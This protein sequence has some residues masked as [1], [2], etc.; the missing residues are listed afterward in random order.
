MRAPMP[1]APR[2]VTMLQDVDP[3]SI[4]DEEVRRIVVALLNLVEQLQADNR[5]LAEENRRLRNE[6]NRLKGEQGKPEFKPKPAPSSSDHSSEKERKRPRTWAKSSKLPLIRIDRTEPLYVDRSTLP[7]DAQHKGYE[8]VVVQDIIFRS[9]NICFRRE[10]FYSPATRR[11]YLAP[12]PEGYEG[13]FGPALKALALHLSFGT[14][15]SE[16]KILD[17]FGSVGVRLSSGGLSNLLIKNQEVFHGEKAAV[18]EAG[19]RS[20][21]WQNLDDTGT[22]V[23]GVNQC[24]QVL[25]NPLYTAY[26]TTATKSRMAV[27]GALRGE[28]PAT[29]LLN[30]EAFAYLDAAGASRVL[31]Q[32]L[33]ILPRDV[34]FAEAIWL[35]LLDGCLPDLG[36]GQRAAVLEA[37]AIAAYRQETSYPTVRMLLC[38]DAPQF[39][40]LTEEL[41]LCWVHEGRH[42][43]KLTPWFKHDRELVDAFRQR[44]WEYYDQ[45][46]V[47][48]EAPGAEEQARLSAAFDDLFSTVTGYIVLD[49]R[50][51]ATRE[52]KAS[53]LKVLEHPEIPLHNNAAELGA[54]GRVRKRDV[55]FGPRT[56][57]GKR[58]WDTFMTLAATTRKLGVSFYEY[59]QDRI[60][61]AG[62][63]PPLAA[64]IGEQADAL[65]LGASWAGP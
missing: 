16:A 27:L 45:L 40:G 22:R 35:G 38:D 25:C 52:K 5:A 33:C 7:P 24:C 26:T 10:K 18:L 21:P 29:Y 13:D 28:H 60:R 43:R 37:T 42:Y 57:D 14:N 64:I 20:S 2:V 8:D 4:K 55:S 51:A 44:F 31:R 9:D 56:E 34:V 3:N 11:T 58:A 6:I 19:L 32:E 15:V 50:I 61:Q 59:L 49:D 65:H 54:R 1:G 47:Y 39:K 36:P 46:L 63:I 62:K 53:L 23:N 12:L 41:A 30:A 17:L 48:R